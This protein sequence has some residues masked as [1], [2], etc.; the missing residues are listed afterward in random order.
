MRLLVSVRSAA[1][2]RAALA[3]G[4]DVVDAKEP[5]AGALGAVAPATLR[6]I[7]RAAAAG[8][9]PVSAALGDASDETQVA[10]AARGAAARGVTFVKIGFRDV[11]SVVQVAAL[12]RAAAAGL[13]DAPRARS[14]PIAGLVL[15][16][17]ADAPRVGGV[18]PMCLVDVAHAIGAA[19]VLVD[20]ARK[21]GGGLFELMRVAEIRA[22][23]DAAHE[24]GLTAA[25]A[26]KLRRDDVRAACA[27]GADLAGVRG[28]ACDGGRAGRVSGARVRQ[29]ATAARSGRE[30]PY[31][32]A[33]RMY[34]PSKTTLHVAPSSVDDSH[35]CRTSPPANGV[36]VMR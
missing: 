9:R 32:P 22:W 24:A 15:V 36:Q 25:L 27:L 8:R 10:R 7:V 33:R 29:L 1:E 18:L 12:A 11:E 5:A 4:A 16:G 17:Y 13:A 34:R 3:G 28:A 6:A 26:G 35:S 31:D 21:D 19:G 14:A 23:V 30:T 2:A 20:T